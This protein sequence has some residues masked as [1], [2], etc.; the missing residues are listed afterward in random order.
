VTKAWPSDNHHEESDNHH[1]EDEERRRGRKRGRLSLSA[2][3]A[4]IEELSDWRGETL[5]RVR[6]LIQQ[7]DFW[8]CRNMI[9]GSLV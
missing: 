2:V 1:E 9:A 4:R 8:C 5:A 6:M 7:A 3:D